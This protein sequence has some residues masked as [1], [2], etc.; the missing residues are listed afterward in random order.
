M[1]N[2]KTT[3][4]ISTLALAVAGVMAVQNAQ[5]L[6]FN[7]T[8]ELVIDWDTTLSYG[9]AWRTQKQHKDLISDSNADDGNRNF[10]KGSMINNRFSVI[11]E[12]DFQYRNYGAFFR[13]S[14]FYD[15][16]YYGKN[17]NDSADTYN[18]FGSHN[19]FSKEVRDAHGS[20]ARILDAFV[21]G[22][23][24]IADRNLSLRVGQQV[25]S[26][27]TSLYI[28]GMST[29]QGPADASKST[30]PG[31]EV[32]DIYLPVGQVLAQFDLTDNLAVSA[33][34]QWEWKKTEVN[35][36]G[37]YFSY[38]DML[39]EGG[40]RL[41]FPAGTSDAV[42][43]RINEN[44]ANNEPAPL[45]PAINSFPAIEMTRGKDVKAKDSGQWGIA[46][47]YYA[48]NLGNGTDLGLYYMN[49][50]DKTPIV[51]RTGS[52]LFDPYPPFANLPNG[53]PHP[54][55]NV[56][57]PTGL[58]TSYHLEYAEDIQLVGTS[59]STI[60]GNTNVGGEVAYRKDAIVYLDDTLGSPTPHRGSTIQAQISAIHSFGNTVFADDVMFTGEIG[61]NR[62]LDVDKHYFTGAKGDIKDLSS[63]RSGAGLAGAVTL[64]Y[65][66]VFS[67]TN[68]EVPISFNKNING[69]SGAG[70]FTSGQNTDK[71]SVGANFSYKDAW[72]AGISYTA[73]FG[74]PEDNKYT[75]RDF[76]AL[77]LKYSF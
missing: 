19:K 42:L 69:N 70:T 3:P 38:T 65:N 52:F 40:E 66:N 12:A 37:S 1:Q 72:K 41:L 54:L 32:K 4:R 60:I 24:D 73:Y 77:S 67:A 57:V 14:A 64:K 61:Y 58:P 15:D 31:V 28:P 50:H 47:E 74:N 35:E 13:G 23:F 21:Y 10:D 68:L 20:K 53:D 39:D 75:D 22:N 48:E 51:A 7:P 25:V 16:A 18:G 29:A 6:S 2:Y 63:D 59:F 44:F 9:A 5:A 27:G 33:Y 45:P 34:S 55:N 49:Y 30:I 71:V 26:W 8:D 43:Q 36:S 11:S 46:F 56:L 62:V 76:V 17:D